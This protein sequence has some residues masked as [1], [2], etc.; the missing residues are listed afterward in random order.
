[1]DTGI[2]D[3]K[4]IIIATGILPYIKWL[5]FCETAQA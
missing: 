2:T 5:N 4:I 1:M 3:N